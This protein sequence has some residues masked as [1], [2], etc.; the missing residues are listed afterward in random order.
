LNVLFA[1]GLALEVAGG[2]LLAAEA[3]RRDP[4]EIA[5]RGMTL[6]S[7]DKPRRSEQV[8]TAR[9]IVGF[10]ILVIGFTVQLLG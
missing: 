7:P 9:A 8:S 1:I 5:R 6:V 2:G 10:V 4:F 3:L